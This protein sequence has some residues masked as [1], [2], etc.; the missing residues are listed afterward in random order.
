MYGGMV[1]GV[2]PR[3]EERGVGCMLGTAGGGSSRRRTL[4]LRLEEDE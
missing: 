4:Q 1:P 3:N 2:P